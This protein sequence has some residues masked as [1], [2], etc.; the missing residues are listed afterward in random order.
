[1]TDKE[2]IRKILDELYPNDSGSLRQRYSFAR[3]HNH[4][5][6]Q[7]LSM[8]IGWIVSCFNKYSEEE[9]HQKMN[10]FFIYRNTTVNGFDFIADWEKFHK[11]KYEAIIKA[12]RYSKVVLDKKTV[13]QG[14]RRALSEHGW[15]IKQHEYHSF[16]ILVERLYN[17]I[18]F[19]R[20]LL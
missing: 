8:V 11:R 14:I 15:T 20:D 12:V 3:M 17:K 19:D 10:G 9:F 4:I 7:M 16:D 2:N 1:M 13:Q 5:M 18:Y 6:M